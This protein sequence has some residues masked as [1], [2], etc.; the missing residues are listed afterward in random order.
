M[1]ELEQKII[2][3]NQSQKNIP[4][5]NEIN[6]EI[7]KKSISNNKK[8]PKYFKNLTPKKIKDIRNYKYFIKIKG[9]LDVND[10]MNS[11][12]DEIKELYDFECYINTYVDELKLKFD[13]TFKN[14]DGVEEDEN[15]RVDCIMKNKLYD[16][17]K[18]EYFLLN[19]LVMDFIV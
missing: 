4:K 17:G 11:I 7:I 15:N 5:E 3:E 9:E 14:N 18:D 10:F 13:I 16:Y 8:Y 12:V 1:S 2:A 6:G 19:L